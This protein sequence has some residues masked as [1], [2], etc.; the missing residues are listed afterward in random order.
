MH[1]NAPAQRDGPGAAHF[2]RRLAWESLRSGSIAALAMVPVGLAFRALD[3]RIGHYGQKLVAL[4]FGSLPP[5][6]FRVV[7]MVEHFAIGW[8]SAAPLL[9]LLVAMKR[10][11]PAWVVGALY[12]AAYYV[13]LNSLLL[14]WAFGD[15]TPWTLGPLTILPSLVIHLVFGISV[16]L[17]SRHF[18]ND[19]IGNLS[20]A[21]LSKVLPSR[22]SS[23][24]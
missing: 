3:L 19:F 18:V 2:A 16:A 11:L 17:T 8:L 12:G 10:R 15:P 24:R 23:S 14:P 22:T 6:P 21:R 7:S 1:T 20:G 4:T 13:A 5:V 9:V